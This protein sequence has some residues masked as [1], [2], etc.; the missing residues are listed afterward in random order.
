MTE[1]VYTAR[2]ETNRL[3]KNEFLVFLIDTAYGH[4][5][6]FARNFR[7]SASDKYAVPNKAGV[8]HVYLCRVLTGT[9]TTGKSSMTKAPARDGTLP[10]DCVVD[11]KKDP[12]VFVVFR[13]ERAYPDYLISFNKNKEMLA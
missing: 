5:V 11:N 7:Y 13:D 8:K 6:Y 3:F 1:W 2:F 4:G 10:Y 9:Y 12:G